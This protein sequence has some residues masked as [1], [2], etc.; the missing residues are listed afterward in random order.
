[1]SP[2]HAWE[3]RHTDL[4]CG[5]GPTLH[6]FQ[7]KFGGILNGLDYE[8]WNPHLDPHIPFHYD[9]EGIDHKAGNTR[10][11]REMLRL[12]D[13]RRPLAAYVGRLDTQKACT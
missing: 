13:G 2:H 10:A 6:R 3:V 12:R 7:E 5:L 9:I 4:G 11:L 1:V 8:M